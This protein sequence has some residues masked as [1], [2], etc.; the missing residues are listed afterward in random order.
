MINIQ[1]AP[2][3]LRDFDFG[4]SSIVGDWLLVIGDS[5]KLEVFE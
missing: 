4:Y 3:S 1:N 5:R 2:K